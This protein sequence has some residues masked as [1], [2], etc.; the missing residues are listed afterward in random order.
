MVQNLHQR[1]FTG[2]IVN[3]PLMSASIRVDLNVD[4][5]K[6]DETRNVENF[7]DGDFPALRP[8]Y[9][10][11]LHAHHKWFFLLIRFWQLHS[12]MLTFFLSNL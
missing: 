5:D 1:D 7:K 11:T 12:S 6:K 8:K 9:D 3:T 2:N 10:R 4:Q